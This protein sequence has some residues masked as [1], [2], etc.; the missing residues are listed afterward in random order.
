MGTHAAR[1]ILRDL[2]GNSREDFV[3]RDKGDLATIG[4]A[5]AVAR[6]GRLKLS[7]FVAWVIW[8]V[9]HILYLIGFRNRVIVMLQWGWAYLTYNRGIRLITG[10]FSVA[11]SRARRG[12]EV[13]LEVPRPWGRGRLE[14]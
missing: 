7:G 14:P 13:P 4:R 6:L 10:D 11:L 1:Q 8:V 9:V 5:A 3:Y 2:A 12:E